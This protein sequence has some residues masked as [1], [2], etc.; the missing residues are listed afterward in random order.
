MECLTPFHDNPLASVFEPSV[1]VAFH[2][3]PKAKQQVQQL[4]LPSRATPM[5]IDTIKCRRAGLEQNQEPLPI[6][7]PIDQIREIENC[8]LGD[9]KFVDKD[10]DM[11]DI[12]A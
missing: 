2:E 8:V 11:V 9:Y 6:F 10:I 5:E 1:F 12:A 3:S 7:A 4:R